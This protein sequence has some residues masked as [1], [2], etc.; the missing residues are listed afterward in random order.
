MTDAD[1][2]FAFYDFDAL[3]RYMS[4]LWK[5]LEPS[6]TSVYGALSQKSTDYIQSGGVTFGL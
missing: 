3:C 1:I 4:R 6:V 2:L 5:F